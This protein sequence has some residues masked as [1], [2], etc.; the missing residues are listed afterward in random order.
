MELF[1]SDNVSLGSISS[2]LPTPDDSIKDVHLDL[3]EAAN[4]EQTV[5]VSLVRN[6]AGT[7]GPSNGEA[8]LDE[9]NKLNMTELSK[10]T[11]P[12][13]FEEFR[14]GVDIAK[15]GPKRNDILV[16]A[17][18]GS[19]DDTAEMHFKKTVSLAPDFYEGYFQLGLEELRQSHMNDAVGTLEHAVSMNA[20]DPRPLRVLGELYLQQKQFQKTVDALVKV[21]TLGA[22]NS[23]DRYH[24]G[25]AFEG[26]DNAAAAQ[27]QFST[28]IS[29]APGKNPQ[30]YLKLHNADIKL[31]NFRRE[32]PLRTLYVFSQTIRITRWLKIASRNCAT[33]SRNSRNA[34]G[35]LY[36][37]GVF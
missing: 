21:G 23:D 16:P 5:L 24:L 20:T 18:G 15:L 28:A 27:Q 7:A 22:L 1:I 35:A 25:V 14:K 11:P 34:F 13:A 19:P 9:L 6:G 33:Y 3:R 31:N 36:G 2:A 12:A 8:Y 17:N 29:L 4:F 10:T 30:A 32:S 37:L 26:L